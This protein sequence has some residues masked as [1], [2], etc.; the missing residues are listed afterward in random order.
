[1]LINKCERELVTSNRISHL[2]RILIWIVISSLLYIGY[3][4]GCF[5]LPL[6]NTPQMMNVQSRAL[7][8]DMLLIYVEL[9]RRIKTRSFLS[10]GSQIKN[11][12]H[13]IEINR[14]LVFTYISIVSVYI[15]KIVCCAC[16]WWTE[17]G[18]RSITHWECLLHKRYECWRDS[19]RPSIDDES[20]YMVCVFKHHKR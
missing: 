4:P 20:K 17:G 6:Q 1:M 7:S 15:K 3:F 14:L 8:D 12:A 10:T 9:F 16:V 18:H 11:S 13:D 5:F 19:N 2:V